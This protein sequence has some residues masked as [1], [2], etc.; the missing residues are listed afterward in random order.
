MS[1][2]RDDNCLNIARNYINA[3]NNIKTSFTKI[4]GGIND[5]D[6]ELDT[7]I[8][9]EDYLGKKITEKIKK[10]WIL[11]EKI[12]KC[13]IPLQGKSATAGSPCIPECGST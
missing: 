6:E 8:I 12:W 9:P 2:N 3:G 4:K 13:R 1:C 5:I 10:S 11:K 7:L